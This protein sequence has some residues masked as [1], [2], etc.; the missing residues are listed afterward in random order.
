MRTETGNLNCQMHNLGNRLCEKFNLTLVNM[1]DTLTATTKAN[2][3]VYVPTLVH[4]YNA[5]RNEATEFSP[6]YLVFGRHLR[7][8]TD[9]AM[10]VE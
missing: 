5:T 8:P 3:K 2:W 9:L 1:L 4:P 10:G 6:F 7:L